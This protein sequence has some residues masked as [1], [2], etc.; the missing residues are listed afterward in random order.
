M[1][2]G[3]NGFGRIGS[4]ILRRLY[5]TGNQNPPLNVVAINDPS[6]SPRNAAYLL[7]QDSLYGSIPDR[8]DVRDTA[9]IVNQHEIACSQDD[10]PS[11][12]G[13]KDIDVAINASG[14]G[15]SLEGITVIHTDYNPNSDITLVFGFN[16]DSYNPARHHIISAGTCTGNA[17]API[18]KVI[19]EKYGIENAHFA[20]VHPPLSD[21]KVTDSPHEKYHLGRRALDTIITTDSGIEKS[22]SLLFPQLKGKIS[23]I[24]HRVPVR[25]SLI[26]ATFFIRKQATIED[27]NLLLK[28]ASQHDGEVVGYCKGIFGHPKVSSDFVKDP[29]AV[30]VSSL[31]TQARGNQVSLVLYHDPEWG[32]VSNLIRL[33]NHISGVKNA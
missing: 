12:G 6:L 10:H 1:K 27:V 9:I 16:Q 14:C 20:S 5:E 33:L 28:E 15:L 13:I 32:Y 2:I 19:D 30:I 31:H 23:G 29:H 4:C 3:I 24:H 25:G 8:V 18:I 21:Q 26:D 11:W 17:L 7:A 22:V